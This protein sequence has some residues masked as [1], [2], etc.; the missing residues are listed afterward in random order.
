MVLVRE[1]VNL[2]SIEI[3]EQLDQK[4]DRM[5]RKSVTRRAFINFQKGVREQCIDRANV[6]RAERQYRQHGCKK[7]FK[8][9]R[10]AAYRACIMR[11]AYNRQCQVF[12]FMI[13]L[14]NRTIFLSDN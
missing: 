9:L 10:M 3:Q 4:L 13:T 7:I 5:G 8:Y 12:D 14:Q 11:R 1:L 6:V 2:T